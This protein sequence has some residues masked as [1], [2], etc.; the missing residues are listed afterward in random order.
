MS[1]GTSSQQPLYVTGIRSGLPVVR[2]DGVNDCLTGTE[3]TLNPSGSLFIAQNTSGD[4][5]LVGSTSTNNQWRIGEGGGNFISTWDGAHSTQG[6]TLR[7]TRPYWFV[8]EYVWGGG[9]TIQLF[10]NGVAQGTGLYFGTGSG[11]LGA[12]GALQAPAA[13]FLT[14]DIGEIL[15]YNTNLSSTDRA[16]VETYIISKW[17]L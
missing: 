14:G 7:A 3:L 2:F 4:G 6:S 16:S 1:Q 9:G 5:C 10:E 11:H 15:V 17:K 8:A 12:I 13:L